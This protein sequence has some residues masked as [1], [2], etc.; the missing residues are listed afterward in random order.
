MRQALALLS[1]ALLVAACAGPEP[2][3]PPVPVPPAQS[4]PPAPRAPTPRAEPEPPT[5]DLS[6]DLRDYYA[7]VQ[8]GLLAQGLLRRDG[9]GVDTPYDADRLAETFL[10]LAFFEEYAPNAGVGVARETRSKLHRW[11]VPVRVETRFGDDV[12]PRQ[13]I[14]DANAIGSLV[15][16]LGAATGHPISTTSTDG[17]FIVY[18]VRESDRRALAPALRQ[19]APELPEAALATVI[20]LPRRNY[21]VVFAV[22]RGET[23]RYTRAVAIIRSEHPELLRLSCFHEEIAQGLGLANDS[24]RARPSIFNDDEEFALLTDMDEQLL[25]ILYDPRLRPGMTLEEARPIVEQ[26]AR[27]ILPSA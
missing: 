17:N 10:R 23:G 22:D 24:P 26:I 7:R 11:E 20:D 8:R 15:R 5:A 4:A 2:V 18:V 27:E 14:T 1:A 12:P 6:A 9:G 3:A 19:L 16:R 21:C 25:S 13:R